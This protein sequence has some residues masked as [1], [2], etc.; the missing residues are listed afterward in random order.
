MVSYQKPLLLQR[1]LRQGDSIYPHFFLICA[2]GLLVLTLP[3]KGENDGTL[4]GVKVIRNCP[5]ISHLLFANDG[6]LF[7]RSRVEEA[8][9]IKEILTL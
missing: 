5:S 8:S 6:L 4:Q 7:C 1:G 3:R 2:E 9:K